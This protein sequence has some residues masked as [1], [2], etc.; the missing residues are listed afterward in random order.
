[1][2]LVEIILFE[3]PVRLLVGFA[4]VIAVVWVYGT[5]TEH[6]RRVVAAIALLVVLCIVM[7]IVQSAVVTDREAI[8]QT[9]DDIVDAAERGDAAFILSRIDAGYGGDGFDRKEISEWIDRALRIVKV[10]GVSLVGVDIDTQISPPSVEIRSHSLIEVRNAYTG[11]VFS[12][13]RLEFANNPQGWK[14]SRITPI[15]IGQR[16]VQGIRD[17]RF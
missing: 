15:A 4:C 16:S 14:I 3:S 13:W 10:S 17:L 1:V 5:R 6:S 11:P 7:L 12:T 2:D 9:I 8:R